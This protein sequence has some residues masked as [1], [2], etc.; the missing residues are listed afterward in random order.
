MLFWQAGNATALHHVRSV[1]IAPEGAAT[2]H[3]NHR[4][5]NGKIR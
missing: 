4:R 3:G 2:R 5:M 1:S